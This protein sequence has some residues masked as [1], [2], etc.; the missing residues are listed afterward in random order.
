L[1]YFIQNERF[2]NALIASGMVRQ[3]VFAFI[4]RDESSTQKIAQLLTTHAGRNPRMSNTCC[5]KATIQL[6]IKIV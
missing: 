1:N 6:I 4:K 5:A 2:L 3:K